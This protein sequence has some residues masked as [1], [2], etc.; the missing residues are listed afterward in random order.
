M[1]D[2]DRGAGLREVDAELGEAADV[3]ARDDIRA[4]GDDGRGFLSA[5][6]CCDF[7]LVDIVGA[8]AAAADVGVGE[9]EKFEAG[10]GAEE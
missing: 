4:G 9:F 6:R 8:G 10:D 1:A 2:A 5:E 7:G 3:S